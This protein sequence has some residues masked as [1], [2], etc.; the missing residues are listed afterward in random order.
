MQNVIARAPLLCYHPADSSAIKQSPM[1]H[2]SRF[3]PQFLIS[4]PQPC[5]YIPGR[6]ERKAFTILQKPTAQRLHDSLSDQ[7]FRRSQNIIYRPACL[8]CTACMSVRVATDRFAPSKSQK[9]TL[10]RNRHLQRRIGPPRASEEQYA[11]FYRY[12][13]SRHRNGGMDRMTEREFAAMI[14]RTPIDS[15][16]VEYRD[17]KT[18]TLVAVCLTDVLKNG[19][20][21]VYSFYAPEQMRRSLGVYMIMDH[22]ALAREMRRPYV[23]LG[24]WVPRSAKMAYKARFSG[25]EVYARGTWKP[26]TQESDFTTA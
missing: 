26:F 3:I 6:L 22:V 24:Y 10:R 7:G 19:V 9:R 25:L 20:S 17:P 23:Y 21:M 12:L 15:R 2:S 8:H 4:V 14:E 11:L 13:A 5:P 18:E 16:L 1:Q